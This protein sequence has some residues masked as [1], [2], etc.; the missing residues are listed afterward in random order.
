MPHEYINDK[1]SLAQLE[2]KE[3]SPDNGQMPPF[4][5]VAANTAAESGFTSIEHICKIYGHQA[6]NDNFA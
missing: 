1:T 5:K 4:A 3:F 2:S 6:D